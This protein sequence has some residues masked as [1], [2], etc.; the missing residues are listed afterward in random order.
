MRD[1]E[2]FFHRV[3]VGLWIVLV[4]V[5]SACGP[6]SDEEEAAGGEGVESPESL[7][8]IEGEPWRLVLYFPGEG[9]GLYAEAREAAPLEKP[10]QRMAKLVEELQSGPTGPGLRTPLPE[11]VKVRQTYLL[12]ERTAVVDLT[13]PEGTPPPSSG[14]QEEM[15]RVYSLV[16]TVVRNEAGVEAVLLLWNGQQPMTFSGHLDLARPLFANASLV[17]EE[18]E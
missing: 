3:Q 18:L 8:E 4:A 2:R 16:N 1:R 5:L 10:E 9:G 6:S 14:S 11:E 15:L 7:E 12:D 13:S 17:Y